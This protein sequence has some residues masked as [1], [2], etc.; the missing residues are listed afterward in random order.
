MSNILKSFGNETLPSVINDPFKK[1][2]VV[3]F[4]TWCAKSILN[5]SWTYSGSLYFEN[6]NT[7]GEQKFSGTSFDD[8]VSQMKSCIQ[9]M[10]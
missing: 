4:T 6:G 9:S 8:V 3:K 5:D 2:K 7:T 1:T 10:E